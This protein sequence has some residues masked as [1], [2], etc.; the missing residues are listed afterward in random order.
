[1]TGF[2]YIRVR[3]L[4]EALDFLDRMDN[5][6]ILAGGTDLI[7]QLRKHDK[8]YHNVNYILDISHIPGLR[9][10]KETEGFI[11][12]GTLVTHSSLIN[13]KLINKNF[14][15]L[16]EAASS[17]GSTQI[18]NRGTIGGNICNAA[19]CADMVPPLLALNAEV[20][21]KS[22]RG[23]RIIPIGDFIKVPNMTEIMPYEILTGI[24]IPLL[25]GKYY[26]FYY[27]VGRRKALNISR[28]T[29]V[30]LAKIEEGVFKDVKLAPGAITSYPVVFSGTQNKILNHRIDELDIQ[31]IADTACSEML[32]ITGERWSTGYKKL[33]LEALVKRAMQKV[34][35][36]AEC[37]GEC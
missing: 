16:I 33:A 5:V 12:I 3:D 6:K 13:D 18:R 28:L 21:L 23:S 32:S 20:I 34:I 37:C 24:R 2:E 11:E 19:V 9:N 35:K 1:M 7:V 14:P 26:N 8:N 4:G 36:E 22:T 30:L 17:I 29:V 10:I 27:K 31:N 25:K 15:V